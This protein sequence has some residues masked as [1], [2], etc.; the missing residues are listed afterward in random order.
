MTQT[1]DDFNPFLRAD[2]EVHTVY[3]L[4]SYGNP[5]VLKFVSELPPLPVYNFVQDRRVSF[6]HYC[7]IDERHYELAS[8]LG[9]AQFVTGHLITLDE[10]GLFN[11]CVSTHRTESDWSTS[12]K[13]VVVRW[14]RELVGRAARARHEAKLQTAIIEHCAGELERLDELLEPGDEA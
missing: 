8:L 7:R 11:S 2:D 6:S 3:V 9:H 1:S 12:L 10:D 14:K 5:R 13:G 4:T